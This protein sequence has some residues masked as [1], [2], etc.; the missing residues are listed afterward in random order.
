MLRPEKQTEGDAKIGLVE[1]GMT[2]V[3]DIFLCIL[4]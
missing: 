2:S 3:Y 4:Q 1:V